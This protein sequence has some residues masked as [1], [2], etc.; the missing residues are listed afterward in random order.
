MSETATDDPL[1]RSWQGVFNIG[2]DDADAYS[3]GYWAGAMTM[4]GILGE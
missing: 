1:L 2:N 3:F 4:G